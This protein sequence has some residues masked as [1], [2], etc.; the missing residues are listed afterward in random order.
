[1]ITIK[2]FIKKYKDIPIDI[3]QTLIID[4]L[5]LT[6]GGFIVGL[7]FSNI[8]LNKPIGKIMND[9]LL[10]TFPLIVIVIIIVYNSKNKDLL[11][12]FDFKKNKLLM[13]LALGF[14]M[15]TLCILVAYLHNDLT[16]SLSKVNA[17]ILIFA[18]ICVFVQSASEEVLCRFYLFESIRLKHKVIIAIIINSLV[19]ALFHIEND[20]IN[21]IS[22]TS[23]FIDAIFVSLLVYYYDDMWIAMAQH[24]A[25]NFNQAFLFGLPN[26][27]FPAYSSLL[28]I[29]SSNNSIFYDKV[30]GI[31]GTITAI[32]VDLLFI[33][34]FALINKEKT[35]KLFSK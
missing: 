20:G 5:S 33:I 13:G 1:M 3:L 23:L 7:F 11:K 31:E 10:F 12:R 32:I 28:K 6:A 2:E 21:A 18:F 35:K 22:L 19:F 15:N 17:L 26:S 25:W 27:G 24:A 14:L 8:D 9:Y 4:F 16:F 34:I 29:S 30:F